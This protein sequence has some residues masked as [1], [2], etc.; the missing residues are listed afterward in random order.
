MAD[1]RNCVIIGRCS[2][3]VLR[4]D[5]RVLKVFLNAPIESRLKRV[6]KRHGIEYSNAKYKIRKEDK[7]R[8]DNYRYCTGRIWGASSNYNLTINTD[9]GSSFI[10][11]CISDTLNA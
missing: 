8:A 5:A 7:Y 2:D 3:Y 6:M 10:E 1:K 4:E 9:L 11:K